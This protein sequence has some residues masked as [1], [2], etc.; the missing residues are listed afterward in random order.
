[1]DSSFSFQEVSHDKTADEI[2]TQTSK[3]RCAMFN[4]HSCLRTFLRSFVSNATQVI[5]LLEQHTTI[6]KWSICCNAMFFL[7]MSYRMP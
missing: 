5:I 6:A 3:P 4:S 2:S 7:S 1:M